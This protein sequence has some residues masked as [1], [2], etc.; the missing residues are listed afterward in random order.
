M[1]NPSFMNF[2]TV[3]FGSRGMIGSALA[4]QFSG[5][6]LS[7][8][9]HRELDITDYAAIEKIFLRAKPQLVLNAAAFT[10]V[11]DCEKFRETAFLVN[12]QAPGHIAALCK[13]YDAFL[14]HFSTDYVFDGSGDRPYREEDPTNP[15][16]YYGTTKWEGDKKILTSGCSHLILRT[17]WIFGKNG[18]NYVKKI[19][20]RAMAEAKL[21]APVDQVGSPTYADDV[22]NA[23]LRLLS[24][25]A[26]GICHF[27][28]SG[29]CSRHEQATTILNL[30]GLNNSVEAVK[31]DDLRV[32]A[33]RPSFSVLDL[34]RY[35]ET[36]GHTPRSWQQSTA[37]YIEFL[38]QNEHELRS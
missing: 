34:T 17:S 26:V 22:A 2:R 15:I 28:N 29:H 14:V 11:D 33:K 1:A 23:V 21:E 18:D 12:A 8:Y 6:S 35:T 30:Y 24:V 37:E 38:K 16:N 31:N 13:K 10:R 36:T 5:S 3:L 4:K 20:K 9:S 19:L 7:S 32:Q 27:S 25:K